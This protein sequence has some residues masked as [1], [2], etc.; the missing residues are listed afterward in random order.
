MERFI[1]CFAEVPDPRG[2]NRR[3]DLAQVLFLAL[4]A[5]LCGAESACDMAAFARARLDLL[6]EI[7]PL[8]AGAP[9][10]DT[11]SRLFRILDPDAF[12]QAFQRFTRAFAAQVRQEQIGGVVALDGKALR[13]CFAKGRRHMPPLLVS[14]WG[15]GARLVLASR[16]AREGSEAKAALALVRLLRL[17]G[18]TLTADALHT[19][20]AFAQAVLEQG[21]DYVLALKGNQAPLLAE[22]Q[23][24]LPPP[25]PQ[26]PTR[27]AGH[28][29]AEGRRASVV[30]A[31]DLGERHGFP[32]LAAIGRVEAWR[33]SGAGLEESVR[34]FLLSRAMPPGELLATVRQHWGIE[35]QLHWVL[36]V[37]LGEDQ[38]RARKDHAP[39]NL[40]RLRRLA[41]NVARLHPDTGSLKGKIKRAGWDHAFLI[42]I[43][44]HLQ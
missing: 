40:A 2:A 38:A 1:A 18:C 8:R 44:A 13:R 15:A 3:H 22:A 30:P 41:L 12:E 19:N 20:A 26:A 10:H 11:F 32:G 23:A 39:E 17:E 6:R 29:R 16:L 24:L 42:S 37:V 7:M 5:V 34:V 36:D 21:G 33:E 35:N 31:A 27:R 28:G 9:S 14:A 4:L 43:L 25:E